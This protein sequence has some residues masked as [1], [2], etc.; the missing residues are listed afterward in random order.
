MR[1]SRLVSPLFLIS[2]NSGK[3]DHCSSLFWRLHL[4]IKLMLMIGISTADT[5][6]FSHDQATRDE[7]SRIFVRLPLDMFDQYFGRQTS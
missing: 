3:L 7:G 6:T 2:F 5:G 1:P 4:L